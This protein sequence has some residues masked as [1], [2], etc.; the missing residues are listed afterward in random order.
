M[1]KILWLVCFSVLLISPLWAQNK[2]K[3]KDKKPEV[4]KPAGFHKAETLNFVIEVS[5]T[6]P[7][8]FLIECQN[9]IMNAEVFFSKIFLMPAG[10]LTGN[11]NENSTAFTKFA[12]KLKTETKL[13][14]KIPKNIYEEW[15]KIAGKVNFRI[16]DK[17]ALFADEWFD[18]DK[19]PVAEREK[20]GVPGAYIAWGRFGTNPSKDE[21]MTRVIRSYVG[22]RLPKEVLAS[23]Y[24]EIGHLYLISYLM[25]FNG[26]IPAWLN[27]GFAELFAYALPSDKKTKRKIQRN[28]AVLYEL[29]QA[30]EY[31]KFDTFLEVTNAHNLKMVAEKSGMSE[32]IYTQAW[33]V[34]EFLTSNPQYS[35]KFLKFLDE[36]RISYFVSNYING[37]SRK[38]M[39]ELQKLA[40]K[41]HFG[42]DMSNLEKFWVKYV[43]IK[44]KSDL[45]RHPEYNFY[46]G[47]FYLRRGNVQ[48]AQE[49][50]AIAA[51]KAP[52]FAESYMGLGRLAYTQKLYEEAVIQFEAAVKADPENS[53][54]YTWLG[55]SFMAT[56]K[57][58]EANT[59]FEKGIELDGD[60][61]EDTLGGYGLS[62]FYTE[63]YEKSAI[64][65][66][67][68]YDKTKNPNYLLGQA[69]SLFMM[70]EYMASRRLF[71]TLSTTMDNPE[72]PF[73]IGAASAYLKEKEYALSE[74]NKAVKTNNRYVNYAKAMIEALN[75]DL[76][77]P[78]VKP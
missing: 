61:D 73:W 45:D 30:N 41:E 38:S 13:G 46:I 11:L 17:R 43:N 78:E 36:L 69:K 39:F 55:Y 53:E 15:F 27:E 14:G 8:S 71:S 19:V 16:W 66:E 6:M 49:F 37:G 74:L 48:K 22:N 70:K 1:N 31:W 29:V 72:L 64:I 42:T 33:S 60:D 57:F 54:A 7:R 12:E 77:L 67:K 18:I 75:N 34:V 4:T 68:A 21:M 51:E 52:K 40:F 3:D 59:T 35:T 25:N 50:F 63:N 24:H 58:K 28:K 23:L 65:Y 2:D 56:G 5:N 9:K 62:L 20:R 44:Y 32:I 26:E 76:P 10:V 47:D